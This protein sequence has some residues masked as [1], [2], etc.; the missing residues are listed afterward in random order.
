MPVSSIATSG[1]GASAYGARSARYSSVSTSITR[2]AAAPRSSPSSRCAWRLSVT[3]SWQ[4]A[5]EMSRLSSAPRRVGLTPTITASMSAAAP[6]HMTYSGVLSRSSPTC[7]G[8]PGRSW[9]CRY[10]ARVAQA[11]TYSGQV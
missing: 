4:S 5:W 9:A 10:A 7:C 6:S 2:P 1:S 8:T 3:M 11:C